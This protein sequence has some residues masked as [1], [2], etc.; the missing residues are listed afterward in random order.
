[1]LH[2]YD[3]AVWA[4]LHIERPLRTVKH[5]IPLNLGQIFHGLAAVGADG[6]FRVLYSVAKTA[7]GVYIL[8]GAPIK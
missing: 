6:I 8:T 7:D 5:R 2:G 3:L 1:M 4:E